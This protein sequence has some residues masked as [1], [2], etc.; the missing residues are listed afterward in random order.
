MRHV[1][2][3]QG[4]AGGAAGRAGDILI[5]PDGAA[6]V[7][8]PTRY[9]DY[10]LKAG[11]TF[12]LDTPGGGGYGDPLEREGAAVVADIREGYVTSDAAE[13]DYGVVLAKG[14]GAAAIDE[15]ATVRRRSIIK[16][17]GEKDA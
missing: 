15:A 7:R 2:P 4:A 13:R 6:P 5:N 10:P 11:D 8:L 17:K 9:A 16:A 14:E 3:P 1:I 12:R